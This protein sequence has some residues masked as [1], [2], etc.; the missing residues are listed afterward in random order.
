MNAA[1]ERIV[2]PGGPMQIE[3]LPDGRRRVTVKA[4]SGTFIPVPTC[5]TAYPIE[6]IREIHATKDLSVC[7]EIV[8]EEDP[9]FSEHYL[10]REVLTYLPP[11]AFAGKRILDFGCGAGA[12]TTA[13]ARLLPPCELVGIDLQARLLRLAVLRAQARGLTGVQFHQ[14]PAGDA[15]PEEIGQFDFILFNA[16]FEHLLPHERP[17]LLRKVWARLKPGGILF[18]NQTP[19][20]YSPV[21][22]HTTSGMLFINYMPDALALRYAR[23]FCKRVKRNEE[24]TTLLRRGIRGGTVKEVLSCLPKNEPGTLLAP[25]PEVGDRIDLWFQTLS[26][27]HGWLKRGIRGSLKAIKAV[28]GAEVPP[29]LSLAIR[30]GAP[31]T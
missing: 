16:V 26:P 31:A 24:W 21:E 5:V 6:L 12:S 7:L 28:T 13:L 29:T 11:E 10:R 18:L 4:S 2:G 23:Y 25:L 22:V 19:H 15:L 3:Q 30:K 9:R 8:R 17:A 14:S 1:I 20:R 27:K